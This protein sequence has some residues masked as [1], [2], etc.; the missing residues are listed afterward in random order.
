MGG[1]RE[2][3]GGREREG[4]ILS[5]ILI[6]LCI[7]FPLASGCRHSCFKVSHFFKVIQ[8]SARGNDQ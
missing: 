1:G 4:E 7:H 8:K 3:E 5:D 6:Y 2:E